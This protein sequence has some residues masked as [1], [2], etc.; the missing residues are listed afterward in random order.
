MKLSIILELPSSQ[1][2]FPIHWIRVLL[3]EVFILVFGLLLGF[4][5]LDLLILLRIGVVPVGE[6][7]QCRGKKHEFQPANSGYFRASGKNL[8]YYGTF[9]QEG[10]QFQSW[11]VDTSSCKSC[12][13][14]A[15]AECKHKLKSNYSEQIQLTNPSM[16][17]IAIHKTYTYI[18]IYIYISYNYIYR[19]RQY[20][21]KR[22]LCVTGCNNFTCYTKLI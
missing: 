7:G 8:S 11:M 9:H 14:L 5:L 21:Q 12:T 15:V 20:M 3:L 13:A 16:H 18:H 4:F 6:K 10:L 17:P 1:R 22:T 19:Q 2:I